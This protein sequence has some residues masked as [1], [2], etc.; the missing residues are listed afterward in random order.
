MSFVNF[1]QILLGN[2]WISEPCLINLFWS[3]LLQYHFWTRQQI[4]GSKRL[5][6]HADIYTVSRCRTRGESEDH[7]SKKTRKGSTLAL[8]PRA[9][10]TR[11]PKQGYQW[12]HEKNI[13]P[14]KIFLKNYSE[15]RI[16]LGCARR[17]GRRKKC[18]NWVSKGKQRKLFT[19]I[20]EQPALNDLSLIQILF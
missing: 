12:H 19:S 7:W 20:F 5:S 11:S 8:K 3:I 17:C 10:V 14:P 15:W 9:D 6:C 4:R 18:N 16:N 2:L 13:C 1:V